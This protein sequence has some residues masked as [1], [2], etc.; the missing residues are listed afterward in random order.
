MATTSTMFPIKH[1]NLRA[2]DR[3]FTRET[4]ARK[5]NTILAKKDNLYPS[6]SSSPGTSP[7]S[8]AG[9]IWRKYRRM[10]PQHL[11]F[12][13]TARHLLLRKSEGGLMQCCCGAAATPVASTRCCCGAAATPV[14]LTTP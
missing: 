3:T 9:Q 1:V 6:T 4:A 13:T 10:Q 14:A 2:F 5:M 8:V 11:P 7:I 12:L